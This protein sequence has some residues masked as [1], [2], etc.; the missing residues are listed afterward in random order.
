MAFQQKKT[1]EPSQALH[2]QL[3]GYYIPLVGLVLLSIG[4]LSLLVTLF[5]GMTLEDPNT[6]LT[7]PSVLPIGWSMEW[8]PSP[9]SNDSAE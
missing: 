8:E 9:A 7:W 2:V 5:S 3:K 6:S 1:L 4:I